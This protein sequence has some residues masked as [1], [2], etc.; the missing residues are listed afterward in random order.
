MAEEKPDEL[1]RAAVEAV[2]ALARRATVPLI[3]EKGEEGESVG[4]GT[5]F[6]V[7]EDHF[8]ITAEHVGRYIDSYGLGVPC[9]PDRQEIWFLGSGVVARTERYDVAVYR[10]DDPESIAQ[11]KQGWEFLGLDNV[12]VDAPTDIETNFFLH[13]YPTK[14]SP[15]IDSAIRATPVA[16]VTT[17]YTGPTD[18][19]PIASR[20]YD[21]RVDLLLN[22]RVRAIDP[23]G[24]EVDVLELKG[25]SGCSVW[26]VAP[27]HDWNAR[28]LWN[29]RQA[30]K[31]VAVETSIRASEWMRCTRWWVVLEAIRSLRTSERDLCF[32]AA[33]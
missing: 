26:T 6:A 28:R 32:E 30:A 22:H 33:P 8:I 9:G 12:C 2:E 24:R 3:V 29:A 18:N 17:L 1:L 20:S 4:T 11:L 10:I 21:P 23:G 25:I 19:F 14:L 7:K 27:P 5:L 15:K 16:L 13:G 31:I